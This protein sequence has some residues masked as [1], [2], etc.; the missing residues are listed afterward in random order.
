M[1]TLKLRGSLRNIQLAPDLT[2]KDQMLSSKG[3]EQHK[4]VPPSSP[5]FP[6]SL[7]LL[8]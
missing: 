3:H 7:E 6:I 2:V 5:L 1:E 4:N 8:L